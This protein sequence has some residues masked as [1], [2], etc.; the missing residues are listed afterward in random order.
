MGPAVVSRSELCSDPRPGT[1]LSPGRTLTGAPAA[2]QGGLYSLAG[3]SLV[4]IDPVTHA[5]LADVVEVGGEPSAIVAWRDK[6]LVFDRAGSIRLVN[7]VNGQIRKV[8][9]G[10]IPWTGATSL[11]QEAPIDL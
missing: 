1:Q 10:R 11:R 8:L 7:P 9:D 4:R 6:I 2:G 3:V 5:I